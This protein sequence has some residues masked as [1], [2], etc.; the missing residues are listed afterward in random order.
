MVSEIETHFRTN[1]INKSPNVKHINEEEY[2][3]DGKTLI[4]IVNEKKELQSK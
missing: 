1:N 2:E 3:F 4:T